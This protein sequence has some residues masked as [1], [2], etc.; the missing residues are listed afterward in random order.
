MKLERDSENLSPEMQRWDYS[1]NRKF[2]E[3]L[4]IH[5]IKNM[6]FVQQEKKIM[7]WEVQ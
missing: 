4:H 5:S 1:N 6:T 7:Q 3:S 2:T